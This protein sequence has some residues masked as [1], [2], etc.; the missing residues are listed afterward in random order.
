VIRGKTQVAAVGSDQQLI[1]QDHVILCRDRAHISFK[2]LVVL[3][4]F[5]TGDNLLRYWW[6]Y[7]HQHEGII[8]LHYSSLHVM[9]PLHLASHHCLRSNHT[10]V[11]PY[12]SS[13]IQCGPNYRDL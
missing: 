1:R 9:S 10:K 5:T 12:L 8:A 7:F 2:L 11:F 3:F 6:T 4:S 13:Y